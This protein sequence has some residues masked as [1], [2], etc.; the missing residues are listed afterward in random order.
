MSKITLYHN[1][2]CSKSRQ[3]LALLQE[4]GIEPT[5]VLYLQTPPD[6]A[7][8][9]TLIKQ[10]GLSRAHDLLRSKEPEYA[11]AGLSPQSSDSEVIAAMVRFP[12]LIERPLAI[13]GKRAVIGRPPENVLQLL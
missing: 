7:T 12:K 9:T 4:N 1:P 11:E 13:R 10:L 2:R 3:A 8:L 5:Q 6:A